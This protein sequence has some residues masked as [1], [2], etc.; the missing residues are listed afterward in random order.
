MGILPKK[1]KEYKMRKIYFKTQVSLITKNTKQTNQEKYTQNFKS[2][3]RYHLKK[4]QRDK[5]SFQ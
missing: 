5:G 4:Q 3:T 1:K 2:L